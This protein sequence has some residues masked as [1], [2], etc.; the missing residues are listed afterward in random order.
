[1]IRPARLLTTLAVALVVLAQ[2]AV[3][4]A[5]CCLIHAAAFG[6]EACCHGTAVAAETATRPCCHGRSSEAGGVD[7]RPQS[8]S[9]PAGECLWCSAEP[10]VVAQD[11]ADLPDLTATAAF[12]AVAAVEPASPAPSS[13]RHVTDEPIH[14]TALAACAWLCVWV[15]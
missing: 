1:M 8:P 13:R 15:I 2:V 6:G 9:A 7:A 4:P 10:K 14:R 3:A 11:R 5:S 12:D